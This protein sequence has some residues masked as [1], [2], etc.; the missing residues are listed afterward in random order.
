MKYFSSSF[1]L[2]GIF[3]LAGG[4]KFEGKAA[5]AFCGIANP[6]GFFDSLIAS[7]ITLAGKRAFADHYAFKTEDIAKLQHEFPGVALVCTEKDAVRIPES[8]R[9]KINVMRIVPKVALGE[10][11][12]KLV[13]AAIR[14]N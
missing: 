4:E 14:S 11:F 5:V 3:A 12:I 8:E 9:S 13:L 2:A 10:E 7:G 1:E 6:E